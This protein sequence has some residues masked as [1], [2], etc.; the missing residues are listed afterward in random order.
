MSCRRLDGSTTRTVRRAA[1]G[2]IVINYVRL[3]AGSFDQLGCCRSILWGSNIGSWGLT[4][5]FTGACVRSCCDLVLAGK[6]V[7]DR[8]AANLV[9][10]Q[11]D[12]VWGSGLGLGRCELCQR[13]VWPRCVEMVQVV[14]EDLA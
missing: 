1:T 4:C 13:L 3:P 11:V 2:K 6:S 10:G 14:G 7:E 12:H 9:T 8:S 5:R